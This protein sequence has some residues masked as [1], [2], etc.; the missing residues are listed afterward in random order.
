MVKL[1]N[2]PKSYIW[3]EWADRDQW[4]TLASCSNS[5][6]KP[7]TI[8]MKKKEKKRKRK[9]HFFLGKVEKGINLFHIRAKRKAYYNRVQNCLT[10]E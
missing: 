6:R 2:W 8:L 1:G 9:G 10:N 7:E 4:W 3:E 5:I